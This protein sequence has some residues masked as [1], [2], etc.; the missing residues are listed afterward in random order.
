M[1]PNAFIGK[2]AKPTTADLTAALGPSKELWDELLKNLAKQ[3]KLVDHEWNSYS[4]KAGWAL[5][6]KRE[7]RNIL[8]LSPGHNCFQVSFVL[9]DKA[10]AATRNAGLPPEVNKLIKGSKRYAEGTGIR[11][12]VTGPS[13]INTVL[14]LTA[15]KLEH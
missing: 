12:E 11:L 5:R 15:I 6:L 14:M 2:K 7:Q 1:T 13:D 4:P 9:G 8:Y 10:V 3:C